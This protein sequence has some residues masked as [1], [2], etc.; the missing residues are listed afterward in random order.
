M[1]KGAGHQ[2]VVVIED[3]DDEEVKEVESL[4][5]ALQIALGVVPL[6][7]I[8]MV[9]QEDPYGEWP[10]DEIVEGPG[11]VPTKVEDEACSSRQP[12]QEPLPAGDEDPGA[13]AARPLVRKDAWSDLSLTDL[14]EQIRAVKYLVCISERLYL[15]EKFCMCACS[16]IFVKCVIL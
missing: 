5:E 2:E 8:A 11:L 16:M 4:K 9:K 12:L 1:R 10:G 13:K 15:H 3:S 6:V 7:D 14:E